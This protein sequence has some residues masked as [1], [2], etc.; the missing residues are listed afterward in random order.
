MGAGKLHWIINIGVHRSGIVTTISF[1]LNFFEWLGK[2]A[3]WCVGKIA[4]WQDGKPYI[5]GKMNQAKIDCNNQL[6]LKPA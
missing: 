1:K 6:V 5:P 3:K 4:T 2:M